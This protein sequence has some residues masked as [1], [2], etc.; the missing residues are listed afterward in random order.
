MEDLLAS[1]GK[2]VKEIATKGWDARVDIPFD[3][4][5]DRGMD[6]CAPETPYVTRQVVNTKQNTL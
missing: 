5:L 4:N 6:S 3:C 1:G 2:S